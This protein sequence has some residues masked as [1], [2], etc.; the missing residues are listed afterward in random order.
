M[1][2][3]RSQ[4][5]PL[6]L[7]PSAA[8]IG[9]LT[10]LYLIYAPTFSLDYLMHDEVLEIGK[11]PNLADEMRF[12]FF[13]YGRGLFGA[14][15]T[16]VYRFVD[17]DPQRVQI[18]RFLNFA[19][20]AL[21][22]LYLL[23]FTRRR[24]S[25][26]FAFCAV[27]LIFAQ[28]PVQG[29]MAYSLQLIS[30]SQPALWLGLAAFH[31]HFFVL[32][33][34]RLPPGLGAAAV[35]LLLLAAS[36]STQNYAYFCMAPLAFLVLTERDLPASRVGRFFALAS[37]SLLASAF[38]F[39][40]LS[41][42]ADAAG[43]PIYGL[44]DDV[45]KAFFESPV[46][47]VANALDPRFYWSAFK[48]WTY[49][50]PLHHVTL[51]AEGRRALALVALLAWSAL[52]AAG[53]ASSWSRT[54]D[55]RDVLWR[56]GAVLGCLGFGAFFLVTDSPS[57][58]KEHRPHVALV[59]TSVCLYVAVWALRDL[60]VRFALLRSP[61]AQAV[62]IGIVLLTAFG[63]Q[64]GVLRGGVAV[65][66]AE[67][68]FIRTELASRPPDSYRRVVVALARSGKCLS[69]PCDIWF[70][71]ITEPLEAHAKGVGRYRYALATLGIDPDSKDLEFVWGRPERVLDDTLVIDWSK[72]VEARKRQRKAMD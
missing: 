39:W 67:L 8:G 51:D 63:A 10:L 34:H 18:V 28:A 36:Q 29:M 69:E 56:W 6:P 9:L 16:A 37:L 48:L 41:R 25:T 53:F 13:A 58:V 30:N 33:K 32:P 1:R 38:L 11:Q 20:L 72:Y 14:Y 50:F 2:S 35:L 24:S 46:A 70:G 68:D 26:L 55:K 43:R 23:R 7:A 19:S 59:L 49:P 61:A 40:L 60:S 3:D 42:D 44:G 31:L 65:R 66:A 27:L 47:F 17:L 52:V 64:S 22:A 71:T 5:D 62:G 45:L 12:Y 4:Q 54:P 21:I 57:G 15:Y